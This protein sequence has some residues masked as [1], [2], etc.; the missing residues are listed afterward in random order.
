MCKKATK[1]VCTSTAVVSPGS[2][3]STASI[4]A[5]VK[6]LENTEEKP[7]D[8]EPAGHGD[9]R[10]EYSYLLFHPSIEALTKNY[11]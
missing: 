8:P 5:T 11:L 9:I 4:S 10:M 3:S 2:L 6:T 7:D 1:S